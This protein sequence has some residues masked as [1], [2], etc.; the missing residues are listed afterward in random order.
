MRIDPYTGQQRPDLPT[1]D[2]VGYFSTTA[3]GHYEVEGVAPGIYDL[4]ASAA[5]YPNTLV[6]S[7]FAV[8]MNQSLHFDVYLFEFGVR[9]EYGAPIDLDGM[10]PQVQAGWV[11][12]LTAGRYYVRAWVF[13]Y[14]QSAR[15][16]STFLEYSFDII[17]NE[18]AGERTMTIEL[19][20]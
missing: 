4:Y 13:R 5:G 3:M 6:Q 17:P 19:C 16:G 9:G 11:N 2:A 14:L 10:V 12:G 8:L 1:V 20:T 15:D 18:R 7:G